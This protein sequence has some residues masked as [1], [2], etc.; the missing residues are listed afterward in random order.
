MRQ[1]HINLTTTPPLPTTTAWPRH[2]KATQCNEGRG[3]TMWA[4]MGTM[5]VP[6]NECLYFNVVT[7][8]TI[9]TALASCRYNDV[10]RRVFTPPRHIEQC[11]YHI[12]LQ[13]AIA[14]HNNNGTRGRAYTPLPANYCQQPTTCRC[15]IA[16]H[17]N[18]E[19]RGQVYKRHCQP[20]N[21]R[22]P[23]A[24]NNETSPHIP[25]RRAVDNHNN[26]E[27]RGRAYKCT[28]VFPCHHTMDMTKTRGQAYKCTLVFPCH[29]TM[30]MTKTRGQA[31]KVCPQIISFS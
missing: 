23:P 30:D 2:D 20:I 8:L 12:P 5:P 10:A 6:K 24:A 9:Y 26:N 18:D 4:G 11:A 25:R 19:T 16:N 31:Y 21:N 17:N 1:P 22:L 28:L 15:A 3:E 27:T 13:H 7:V 29:H 14:N